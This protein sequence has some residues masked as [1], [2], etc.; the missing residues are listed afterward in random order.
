MPPRS[1]AASR[2]G[3]AAR[4]R[5]IKLDTLPPAFAL[6]TDCGDL[7]R[8]ARIRLAFFEGF[9]LIDSRMSLDVVAVYSVLG[10]IDVVHV[11]ERSRN[12]Q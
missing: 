1:C 6:A 3:P 8:R 11:P 10:G 7:R 2:S 4:S 5:W 12:R 9:V